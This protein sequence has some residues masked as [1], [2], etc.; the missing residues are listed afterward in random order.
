[1]HTRG[2]FLSLLEIG[3]LALHP[4]G[5][6]VGR[7]GD[8]AVD[9]AVA[10][11]LEA[12]VALAGAGRLPVEVDVTAQDAAGDGARLC[13][14]QLLAVDGLAVLLG[15]ALGV[16]GGALGDGLVDGVVEALEP[17]LRDPLVLDGL[18]GLARLAGLFSGDHEV[19]KGLQVGVGAAL[20]EGVVAGVDGRGDERGGLG[21][22]A[23]NGDE[24]GAWA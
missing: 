14:G 6:A 11:A 10:A 22:G 13:V 3:Q 16:G 18:E 8:G 7:V 21:V 4:D 24:V 15:Q 17:G 12:V 9:G 2:E 23:G 5:V 20:D 1:M 19:V